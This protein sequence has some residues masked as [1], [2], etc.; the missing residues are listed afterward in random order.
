MKRQNQLIH[1]ENGRLLLANMTLYAPNGLFMVLLERF[2][3]LT[4]AIDCQ[5]DDGTMSLTFKS[6]QAYEYALQAWGYVN[7]NA[8]GKFLLI[9]NHKGCGPDEERQSYMLVQYFLSIRTLEP[10]SSLQSHLN[11]RRQYNS[12]YVLSCRASSVV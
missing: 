12:H 8:N 1:L 4:S 7:A 10:D 2:D 6:H 3:H 11:Q 9:A 5:G